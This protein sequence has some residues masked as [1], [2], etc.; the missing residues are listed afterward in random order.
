MKIDS[1]KK[2]VTRSQKTASHARKDHS[3]AKYK[4]NYHKAALAKFK[5]LA[6]PTEKTIKIKTKKKLNE[7]WQKKTSGARSKMK[8]HV[9]TARVL[10]RQNRALIAKLTKA[11]K[12]VK[13]A[14]DPGQIPLGMKKVHDLQKQYDKLYGKAKKAAKKAKGKA[15]D[16]IAKLTPFGRMKVRKQRKK[17]KAEKLQVATELSNYHKKMRAAATI[18]RKGKKAVLHTR[19]PK[20]LAAVH[21]RLKSWQMKREALKKKYKGKVAVQKHKLAKAKKTEKRLLVD[22][23]KVPKPKKKKIKGKVTKQQKALKKAA[24]KAK[25]GMKKVAKDSKK[26]AKKHAKLLSTDKKLLKLE[27]K[28]AATMRR[29]HAKALALKIAKLKLK[30]GKEKKKEMATKAKVKAAEELAQKRRQVLINDRARAKVKA[31]EL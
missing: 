14:Q 5:A 8:K 18:I 1:L 2:S 22:A 10:A 16:P 31:V 23:P 9:V 28:H 24:K 25:S 6:K 12:A 17:I 11:Q 7:K 29:R 15:P 20:K 13:T 4:M 3:K 27:A 30:K 19:D 21:K 26:A